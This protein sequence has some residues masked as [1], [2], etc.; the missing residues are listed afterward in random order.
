MIKNE[1]FAIFG[2]GGIRG[3]AYCGAYKALEE[4]NIQLSGCAGS[5][6]GSVFATLLSIGYSYSEIYKILSDVSFDMF[7]DINMDIKK[8]LAISKGKIFLEWIREKI[9]KKFY[10]ISYKKGEM[11][12]VKFSDLKSTLIIFKDRVIFKN[13]H[14]YVFFNAG[15]VNERLFISIKIG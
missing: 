5:S 11:P 2:G 12:P 15:L 13:N 9:E 6:I 14:E 10:G 8:E 3:L 7:I 4:H 1:H